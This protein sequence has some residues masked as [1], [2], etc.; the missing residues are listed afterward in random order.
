MRPFKLVCALGLVGLLAGV[1]AGCGNDVPSGSVA[2]VGDATITKQEFDEWLATAAAIQAQGGPVAVPDPPSYSKCVAAKR[3]AAKGRKLSDET[4]R[5]QCRQRYDQMRSEV[6]QFLIQAEWIQQEAE[7]RGV[8]VSDA[9]AKRTLEQQR[10]QAFPSDKA[11][12]EYIKQVGMS[13]QDL[14]FRVKLETLEQKLTKD[15]TKGASKV[16]AADVERYFER[17]RQR[18]AQPERRDLLIVLTRTRA[19]AERA[20]RALEDGQSWKAVARRY[21]I[22]QASKAQGGK[23]PDVAEGQQERALDKAVFSARKGRVVGPVKTQFGW[24]LFEV[25]KVTPAKQGSLERS[26]ATIRNVL[27]SEREQKALDEFV[28]GFREDHK[29]E[30]NCADGYTVAECSN[31]PKQDTDTAGTTGAPRGQTEGSGQPAPEEPSSR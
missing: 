4:L 5:K 26:R 2:K 24:Y 7:E 10:K 3:K 13:E 30:T 16:S 14:L 15:A 28:K 9:E 22:D 20:K 11:Y 17:N 19:A 29:D 25:T 6:M 8:K 31:A 21:S 27:R 23:L 18:F 1:L 12:R